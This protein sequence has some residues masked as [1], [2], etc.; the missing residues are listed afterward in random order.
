MR[1]PFS[2][3]PARLCVG[4]GA[5]DVLLDPRTGFWAKQGFLR[6][7]V[8]VKVPLRTGKRIVSW[9]LFVV[10]LDLVQETMLIV[11]R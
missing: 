5:L 11:C 6:W 7:G 10:D 3:Q 1:L 9:P 2:C 8:V 4:S